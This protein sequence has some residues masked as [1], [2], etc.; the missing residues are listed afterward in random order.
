MNEKKSFINKLDNKAE[1]KGSTIKTIWQAIKFVIV[2][3]LVTL[4]QLT[5]VNLLY[6]LLDDFKE[7]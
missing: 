5:L 3:L 1:S 7:P 2:S 6:F 4:I